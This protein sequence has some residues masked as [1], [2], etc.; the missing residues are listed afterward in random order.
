MKTS[1]GKV[2]EQVLDSR[3]RPIIQYY[4]STH[5]KKPCVRFRVVGG[6]GETQT[7]S[8]PYGNISSARRGVKDLYCRLDQVFGPQINMEDMNG[9]S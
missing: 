5:A 8:E 4:K 9:L 3:N 2:I 7:P 1:K 6:N